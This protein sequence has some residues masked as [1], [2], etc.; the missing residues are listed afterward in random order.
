MTAWKLTARGE[1]GTPFAELGSF[2]SIGDAARTIIK[3]EDAPG[4]T[5]AI[6]FRVYVDPTRTP[7]D[8]DVLSR[9]EYQSA[10]R[11]YLLTRS[12]H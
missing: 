3:A 10:Q 9:L 1:R 8:A 11:F 2:A 5:G 6:F 12:A 4:A 7:S